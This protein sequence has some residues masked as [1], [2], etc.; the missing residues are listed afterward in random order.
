MWENDGAF[1]SP[2]ND[3]EGLRTGS[4]TSPPT[5]VGDGALHVRH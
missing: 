3:G 4:R 1:A 5:V 2:V